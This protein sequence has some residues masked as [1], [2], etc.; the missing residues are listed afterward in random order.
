M[1]KKV[2]TFYDSEKQSHDFPIITPDYGTCSTASNISA[3]V[4]I[5]DDFSLFTG[6]EITVK[7]TNAPT[8][9][10]I[11]RSY[12]RKIMCLCFR[13]IKSYYFFTHEISSS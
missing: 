3:K 12:D 8:T 7:F 13:I 11:I 4:V 5:C 1:S 6:A 2:I 9:N 10:T